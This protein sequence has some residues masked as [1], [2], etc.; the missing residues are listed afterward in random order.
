MGIERLLFANQSPRLILH[1]LK[2]LMQIGDAKLLALAKRSIMSD[3]L[4]YSEP[5]IGFPY[6]LAPSD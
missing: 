1:L 3:A 2:H 4:G 5:G 6:C